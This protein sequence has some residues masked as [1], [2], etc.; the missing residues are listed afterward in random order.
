MRSWIVSTAHPRISEVTEWLSLRGIIYALE[1]NRVLFPVPE[2]TIYTEFALRFA[3]CARPVGLDIGL[4]LG[5][6]Y[7][8]C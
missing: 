7:N 2:G 1:N 5:F 6:P 4:A 8:L 3:D